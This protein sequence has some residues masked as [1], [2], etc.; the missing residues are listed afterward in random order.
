MGQ[1]NVTFNEEIERYL[2]GLNINKEEFTSQ[3]KFIL[4]KIMQEFERT[5]KSNLLNSL[6]MEDYDEIPVP[7]E[8]YL[9]D[10]EYA[11]NTTDQGNGIWPFWRG[12]LSKIFSPQ[13][14]Y[15]KVIFGGSIGT[16][17]SSI[18]CIGISYVIYKLLCLKDPAEYYEVMKGSKPGIAL[19]NITLDKGF[20]VAFH[21]INSIC[22]NSPWF[23]RNGDLSGSR[24]NE[25]Y[26]PGKGV[27]IGVGSMAD[28]FIGLDTFACL[29][30]DTEI[31]T[32]SGVYPIASL[33][34][35]CIRVYNVDPL[36]NF[37]LSSPCTVKQTKVV[38]ELYEIELENGTTL[39][40]TGEHLL[41]LNN[42]EY[43]MARDLT[44]MDELMSFE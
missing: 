9:T 7:I 12:V 28:H 14:Q 26:L 27:T 4:K 15:M 23:L 10:P 17:K 35:K 25:V 42:G 30:G 21:K 32:D 24:T 16:G 2:N 22:K 5:G 36:G 3:E 29:A 43:K 40:C 11:G 41:M 18:A 37:V 31:C 38:T 1:S 20:G 13:F 44:E 8:R 19:F 39:R 34:D 33:E 6:Y